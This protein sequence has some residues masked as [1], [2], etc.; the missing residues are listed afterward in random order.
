MH[1]QFTDGVNG[2]IANGTD[3]NA[4]FEGIMRLICSPEL[5]KQIVANLKAVPQDGVNE[6]Q[7]LYDYIES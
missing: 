7:K 3:A 4:L 2:I 6:I 1:E 5:T